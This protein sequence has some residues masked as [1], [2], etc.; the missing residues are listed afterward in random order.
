MGEENER[1]ALGWF[2]RAQRASVLAIVDG[3]DETTLTAPVPL[4][5]GGRRSA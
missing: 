3:L 1:A 4:P 5:P 2:L